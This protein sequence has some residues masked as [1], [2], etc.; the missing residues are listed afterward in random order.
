M[1][2]VI[3]VKNDQEVECYG[4]WEEDTNAEC[5]FDNEYL[6]GF[7]ADGADSW[8]EA[9]EIVTAYAK[10]NGTTLIQMTAC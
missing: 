10:S 6:D 7:F 8:D 5:I 1:D 2:K 3:I 9:V 4:E